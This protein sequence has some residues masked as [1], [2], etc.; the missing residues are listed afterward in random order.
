VPE[1]LRRRFI[2]EADGEARV[3][4]ALARRV[5]FERH[6]LLDA[7]PPGRGAWEVILCRNV[8]M[9]F[10]A[11]TRDAVVERLA[12]TLAPGGFL[13]LGYAETARHIDG[14]DATD[15]AG[16]YRRAQ[17]APAPIPIATPMP[18]PTPTA[19]PAPIATPIRLVGSPT[20]ESVG[21][22]LRDALSADRVV[23]DLDGAEYLDDALAPVLRRAAAAVRAS[24]GRLVLTATRPGPRRWVA[25]HGL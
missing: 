5:R 16:V 24:G 21:V 18:I 3:A 13:L 11:P 12:A 8:L 23:V 14:L 19:I 2:V 10:D 6:N 7:P 17:P 9:Y 22:L 20:A 25:R 1:A 15:E 4:P